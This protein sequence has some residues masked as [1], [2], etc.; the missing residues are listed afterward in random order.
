MKYS[1]YRK[2]L[3][4]DAEFQEATEQLKYQFAFGDAVLERRLKNG[5]SQTEL[6]R[7]S[8]TKQ[9]NISRIEAGMG[10]PTL[11]L[12]KKICDILDLELIFQPKGGEVVRNFEFPASSIHYDTEM[13]QTNF[14]GI[15]EVSK[16][17]NANEPGKPE[18][19]V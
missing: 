1:D 18:K 4:R 13:P 9:A 14:R 17:D 16:P 10:N 3:M 6:A 5:W 2:K 8:G 11:D 7:R 12:I 15:R 19:P